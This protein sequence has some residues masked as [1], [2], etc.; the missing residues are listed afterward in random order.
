MQPID[1]AASLLARF[2]IEMMFT[3][4][5]LVSRPRVLLLF[6]FHQIFSFAVAILRSTYKMEEENKNVLMILSTS[7]IWRIPSVH[8]RSGKLTGSL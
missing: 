2:W 1:N 8:S 3:E 4:D 7:Y 5:R 6:C